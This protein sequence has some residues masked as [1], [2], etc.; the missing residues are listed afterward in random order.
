MTRRKKKSNIPL[1]KDVILTTDF[2][3][4]VICLVTGLEVHPTCIA[5]AGSHATACALSKLVLDTLL[6]ELNRVI[7]KIGSCMSDLNGEYTYDLPTL[8]EHVDFGIGAKYFL[9]MV[10][11]ERTQSL[12]SR[13]LD[14]A[15]SRN[16][17]HEILPI[18]PEGEKLLKSLR[19]FNKS[20]VDCINEQSK[21]YTELCIEAKSG[22]K[23]DKIRKQQNVD[24]KF[25]KK[26]QGLMELVKSSEV[27][28]PLKQLRRRVNSLIKLVMSDWNSDIEQVCGIKACKPLVIRDLR[29]A[30]Q[31]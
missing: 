3:D 4:E 18:L 20:F 28:K 23:R 1:N 6:W 9:A 24:K 7:N 31:A 13:G 29:S 25:S 11:S 30:Q 8:E 10:I 21:G 5:E 27:R 16:L 22:S 17:F 14:N 26:I 19:K 15:G 12:K 2:A